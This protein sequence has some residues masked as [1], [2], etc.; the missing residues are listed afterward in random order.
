MIYVQCARIEK[1]DDGYSH[2]GYCSSHAA[3][4]EESLH[5]YILAQAGDSMWR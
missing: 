4:A 2:E 1:S 3:A 5:G